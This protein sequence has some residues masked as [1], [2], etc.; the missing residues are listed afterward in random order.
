[1]TASQEH[2]NEDTPLGGNL[3]ADGAT[4]RAWAPAAL[5]VYVDLND[6]GTNEP[7]IW[8]KNPDD[9]LIKD[10]QGVW[11]GF[12]PGVRDGTEYRFYVVGTGSEGFKRD[13]YARELRMDGY[14][15]CNC[16]V[17]GPN[18]YVWHDQDFKA[19][20][21]NDLIIY[22]FHFGVFYAKDEH[23]HDIR[24]HRVCKFLDV[25][26]RIEYFADLGINAVMPLPFQ[27]YQTENSLGYNGT[28]LFSPEMDYAV[29]TADLPH[30]LGRIN[31][32]L[33]SK[34]QAE[35]ELADLAGQTNQLKTLIDLCHLYGIGVIADVVYNHA[36]SPFDPQSLYFFDRLPAGDNNDSLYFLRDGHA[37]GLVFAFHKPQVRKFLIDNGRML[38][39][40]YHL[41]GL[42]YDQ[43]TVI[44]EHGGWFFCQE[45]TDNLSRLKP[46]AVQ[47]AEYWGSERWKGIAKPPDGMG[48][49]IGYSDQ[50]RNALREVISESAG[51]HVNLD[52][53]RD[54]LYMSYK[55]PGRSSVF[56]CVENHD[57]LDFN[58]GDRQP[59]IPTLADPGNHRSWRARSR[60]KV[61][62]GLLLTAPGVPMIFMGQEFLEDK[63]WTDWPGRPELLIYWAG[64]E[65]ADKD[66]AD[67]HSF[68]RDLMWLRRKQPALRGEGLN[69]F[70]VHN[71]NR[72]IGF[73]RWV[74]GESRDIIVVASLNEHTFYDHS[75]RI[76]FPDSGQWLEVFNS[77]VYDN[78]PNPNVQGNGGSVSASGPA[79]N[80]MPASS[81]ITLPANTILVFARDRGD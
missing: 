19:P 65:G 17:R 37:G 15:E 12:F 43:V 16:I 49:D 20:P 31:R 57:L 8:T 40:E 68:T 70:H 27:E 67:Q 41:D 64:L 55:D 34:G 38:L 56:Q 7:S 32:L 42:R 78:F 21:F 10:Q 3:V 11:S 48:F 47:I 18:S 29:R 53:V 33:R 35:V 58:H 79:W 45:L 77:D 1:M 59:R 24:P 72:V 9:L 76:G 13:P 22:Q 62:T 6:P 80:G 25:V 75:Y 26:D 50:L 4:F 14:P 71:D 46:G 60:A 51:D 54:A 61:A 30:Y 44:D 66:M 52:K 39:Q 74:P 81:G 63:Y 2:I 73:H 36:G 69:V 23:G 28:D 5:Q